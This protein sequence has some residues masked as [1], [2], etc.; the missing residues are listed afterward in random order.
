LLDWAKIHESFLASIVLIQLHLT[1]VSAARV[2][3]TTLRTLFE[4]QQIEDE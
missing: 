4:L 2:E 3:R 1:S